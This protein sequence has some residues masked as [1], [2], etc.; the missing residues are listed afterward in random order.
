MVAWLFPG[1]GSQ[2]VGMAAE[3]CGVSRAAADA[4]AEASDVLGFDL[5]RLVAEGPELELADTYNQQPAVLAASV[6][7]LR[8]VG[9]RLPIPAVV[10]GHSLGEYTALVAAGALEYA[11]ALRLVR[12]RGRLMRL[13]G[14]RSPGGMAAVLGLDDATVEAVCAETDGVQVANYNAPG[15]VVVSGTGLGVERATARLE[16]LGARRV[17][18]LPITIAA[19]SQLMASVADS[20]HQAVLA[21]SFSDAR[22]PVVANVSARGISSVA[23]IRAELAEQLTSPVRWTE[24][25]A[26]M[27]AS[28]VRSFYEIG[29][30]SVLTGLARRILKSAAVEPEVLRTLERPD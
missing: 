16:A 1:Q 4:L 19:H 8:A 29:P 15:Q 24:S 25:V 23:E 30:G 5:A 11:E 22:V 18:R 17:V 3:W 12:E 26:A 13:A 9:D 14:E 7:V 20:F 27:A 10:A 2:Y 28:G 6:A 21:A